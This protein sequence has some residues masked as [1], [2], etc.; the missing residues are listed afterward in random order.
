MSEL[1]L[2]RQG[3]LQETPDFL[4]PV[5]ERERSVGHVILVAVIGVVLAFLA[6]LLAVMGVAIVAGVG[7][8]PLDRMTDMMAGKGPD[9]RPLLDHTFDYAAAGLA[10]IV[11]AIA[12]VAFAARIYRRP[13]KSFITAAPRFRWSH[14]GLGLLVAAPIVVLAIVSELALGGQSLEP[15][16]LRAAGLGEAAAYVAIAAIFLFLAA[17]AE[18]IFFRGWLLQQTSAFTRSVP[19]LLLVNGIIFSLIHADPDPGAFIVRAAMGMG[20][21]WVAL[22]L[23]GLEF[24]TGAHLANNLAI[25]VLVEPLS[26]KMPTSEPSAPAA[27]AI[28]LAIVALTLIIVEYWLRRRRASGT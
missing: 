2:D 9:I 27:V 1:I 3:R 23:G 20:W 25:S 13:I 28:Q 5:T 26:L 22:R 16:I 21:C 4:A 19:I 18:E 8:M 10:L 24:A 17:F 12:L 14:F 7:G 11:M 15:P 6:S